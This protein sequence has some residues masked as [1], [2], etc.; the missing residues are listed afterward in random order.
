M[1]I[2]RS[3]CV[4]SSVLALILIT[5]VVCAMEPDLSPELPAQAPSPSK[6]ERLF[7]LLQWKNNNE[8][9]ALEEAKKAIVAGVDINICDEDGFTVLH[10]ALS[11]RNVR[12][13]HLLLQ[14]DA[15][16]NLPNRLGTRPIQAAIDRQC[17]PELE[18]LARYGASL[19]VNVEA[20]PPLE[21]SKRQT[22]LEYA[23]HAFLEPWDLKLI[24]YSEHLPLRDREHFEKALAKG[25]KR[26]AEFSRRAGILLILYGIR[27]N[28]ESAFI[29]ML[30][31]AL[32]PHK[33]LQACVWGEEESVRDA[34]Q[35]IDSDYPDKSDDWKSTLRGS[36]FIIALSRG[37]ANLLRFFQVPDNIIIPGLLESVAVV[38]ARP[39]LTVEEKGRYSAV[40]RVL[41][42]KA[43]PTLSSPDSSTGSAY[44]TLFTQYLP[45]ELRLELILFF[46]SAL[47][48]RA[49]SSTN[50]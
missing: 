19:E 26:S 38:R 20:F 31:P 13:V 39:E 12:L 49:R 9:R 28:R 23:T 1:F 6:L 34:L 48:Q 8:D 18:L 47:V 21:E 2:S 42:N 24:N 3:K 45:R 35:T 16:P 29:D 46:M 11:L 44:P 33:L 17:F 27:L 15:D 32:Y 22:F 43:I 41:L 40:M 25:Y 37:H 30:I 7:D 10:R 4:L 14:A 50:I 36:A 5:S